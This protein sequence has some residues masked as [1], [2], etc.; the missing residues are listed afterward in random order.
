MKEKTEQGIK[1]SV[2]QL[3]GIAIL[4]V[5]TVTLITYAVVKNISK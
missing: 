2:N 4:S 1:L 3:L 5:A